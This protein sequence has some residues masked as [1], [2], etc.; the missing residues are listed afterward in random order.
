MSRI[1]VERPNP[2]ESCSDCGR[3]CEKCG[4]CTPYINGHFLMEDQ[5]EEYEE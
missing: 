3:T 4:A 1:K 2:C 5:Y